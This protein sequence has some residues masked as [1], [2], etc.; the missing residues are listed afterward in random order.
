MNWAKLSF[1]LSAPLT[2]LSKSV[3]IPSSKKEIAK[4]VSILPA[5][6]NA[7]IPTAASLEEVATPFKE[8]DNISSDT[9][10]PLALLATLRVVSEQPFKA[11]DSASATDLPCAKRLLNWR[12]FATSFAGIKLISDLLWSKFFKSES[13][14][15]VLPNILILVLPLLSFST[16]LKTLTVIRL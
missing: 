5:I 13:C 1:A 4:P 12:T 8:A 7:F 2:I 10:A 15:I 16:V 11:I 14:V 3:I 9:A 6:D